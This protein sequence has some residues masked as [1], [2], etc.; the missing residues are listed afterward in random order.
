[1]TSFNTAM[2]FAA[3]RGNIEIVKLFEEWGA[4]DFDEAMAQAAWGEG[5]TSILS[6]SKQLCSGWLVLSPLWENSKN[7]VGWALQKLQ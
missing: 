3:L 4:T 6:S 7:D 5:V 2:I 1:M